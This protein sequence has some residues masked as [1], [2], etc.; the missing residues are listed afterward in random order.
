MSIL[1]F[2]EGSSLSKT[3]GEVS[4]ELAKK[5]RTDLIAQYVLDP[6]KIFSFVGYEGQPGLC[7]SGVFIEAAHNIIQ[8]LK[9]LGESHMHAFSALAG[10]Q[11]LS[12]SK[13]IDVGPLTQEIANRARTCSLVVLAENEENLNLA[14]TLGEFINC[15]ILMVQANFAY[16][17]NGSAVQ[18]KELQSALAERYGQ[19]AVQPVRT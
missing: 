12:L 17:V 8:A 9:N 2:I 5:L 7:G 3:A 1:Y 19:Q 4:I 6:R 18:D 14:R 10:G 13:F 11:E 15:P 16:L